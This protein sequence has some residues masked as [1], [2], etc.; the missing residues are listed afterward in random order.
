MMTRRVRRIDRVW[1][2]REVNLSSK[3]RSAQSGQQVG[4]LA[5]QFPLERSVE[6]F[7]ELVSFFAGHFEIEHQ[8]FDV[9]PK[10]RQRFLNQ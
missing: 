4:H 7:F 9:E 3:V 6:S 5:R 1:T 8:V 2:S 10:L